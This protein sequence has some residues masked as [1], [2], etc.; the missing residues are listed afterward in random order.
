[1][2]ELFSRRRH[3]HL[4]RSGVSAVLHVRVGQ[5]EARPGMSDAAL[6]LAREVP[7]FLREREPRLNVTRKPCGQST[8]HDEEDKGLAVAG[9]TCTFDRAVQQ[10]GS[11]AQPAP[12]PQRCPPGGNER[13][14]ELAL[15]GGTRD[16]DGALA[17]RDRLVEAFQVRLGPTEV[18]DGIEP[19]G[20]LV[21]RHR[22]DER[23]RLD[24]VGVTVRDLR[25]EGAQD[26]GDGVRRGVQRAVFELRRK[27]DR[28]VDPGPPPAERRPVEGI[29]READH[30]RDGLG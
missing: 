7:A 25:R 11:V 23:R 18:G 13:R 20:Q 26:R 19:R 27:L 17:V 10:L 15:A 2:L 14:Q 1:M 3:E 5:S 24:T 8:V 30:Q 12:H 6:E 29:E 9:E 4:G 16:G 28:P 21:V 22:I